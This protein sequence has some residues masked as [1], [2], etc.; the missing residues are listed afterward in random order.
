[1]DK[2]FYPD[3]VAVIGVSE[4]PG[5]LAANIIA[6]MQGFGYNG[7]IYAVGLRGGEVHGMPILPSVDGLPDGV[8]LAVILTPA[9]TVPDLLEACGRK[10]I[11]RAVIESGGFSE[12]SEA[13]RR[14][15]EQVC[16]TARRWNIRFVGPNC[17]SVVNLENGLCL[18]FAPLERIAAKRGPVSVLAQSG[19]VSITYLFL[20]SEAGLGI[21]SPIPTR[22]RWPATTASSTRP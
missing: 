18:P 8:D 10:G 1:M 6:N 19:G 5:N 17:I 2:I 22:R 16:E 11:R 7:E 15:E 12:F 21:K 14:L 13:G 3:S 9:A 20:L 4:R